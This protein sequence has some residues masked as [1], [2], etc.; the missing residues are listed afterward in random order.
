MDETERLLSD[1]ARE[2]RDLR[3]QN[4]L[5]GAQVHV[6]NLFETMLYSQPFV[7]SRGFA[8]DIACKLDR[9]VAELKEAKEKS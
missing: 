9:K 1:A 7:P 8:E 3:R 2:I 6:M 5:L 4:E